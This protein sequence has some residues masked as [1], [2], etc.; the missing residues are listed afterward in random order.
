MSDQGL[1]YQTAGVDIGESSR[2]I[3]AFKDAVRSTFT[4]S[5]LSDVGAFGGLFS[6]NFPGMREPV[7]V[8]SIDGVGTKTKVAAMVG[9]FRGLGHD[10]VNHCVN[11]ILVQGGRPLF[12][13]DYIASSKISAEVVA[14]IVEGCAEA[15]RA[16]DCALIGGETAEM[17]GVYADREIDLVGSIVGVVEKD[18]LLPR[19]DIGNG[20]LIVGIASDGLHTN[21]FSLARKALF[22]VGGRSPNDPMPGVQSSLADAL[23]VPHRSYLAPLWPVLHRVKGL[24]HITGGGFI[25]NVP[26]ILGAEAR[27]VIERNSWP[28]PELFRLIQS[29]GYISD[30]EMYTAFNMGIGMVAVT[31]SEDAQ[32]I[33]DH[34][35]EAGERAWIIG[36]ITKGAR[37]ANIV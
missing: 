10:I 3:R 15:C 35:I 31:A 4:P 18:F 21:G 14:E 23:L 1:S 24:A 30:E 33:V 37:G 8:S 20:D 36:E 5:V 19:G 17:P 11:D 2:A 6:A 32:A 16:V 7:L 22:E 9:K 29:D 34:L 26:R 13:L 12:F 28:V 27:A 25:E